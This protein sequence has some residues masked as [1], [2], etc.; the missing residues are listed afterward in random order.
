MLTPAARG[1]RLGRPGSRPA[2]RRLGHVQ[3]PLQSAQRAQRPRLGASSCLGASAAGRAG[4]SD[5]RCGRAD[6]AR[7]GGAPP[8]GQSRLPGPARPGRGHT[9]PAL[10][11]QNRCES[12]SETRHFFGSTWLFCAGRARSRGTWLWPCGTG[13]RG[14][15]ACCAYII[16]RSWAWGPNQLPLAPRIHSHA[17]AHE[18]YHAPALLSIQEAAVLMASEPHVVLLVTDAGILV[19][20]RKVLV[21]GLIHLA[22]KWD[23]H[24]R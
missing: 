15:R 8:V 4:D 20:E 5:S 17:S 16:A 21:G 9:R 1:P 13:V 24:L 7:L 2:L 19:A 23:Q 10:N 3:A 12:L 14:R 11:S 18:N 6:A 22:N